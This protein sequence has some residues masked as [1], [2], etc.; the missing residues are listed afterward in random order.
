[1]H[2]TSEDCYVQIKIDKKLLKC[3]K[4]GDDLEIKKPKEEGLTTCKSSQ[5]DYKEVAGS[6]WFTTYA[7]QLLQSH[8][9]KNHHITKATL[10]GDKV[11]NIYLFSPRG[12]LH[13][14]LA[15]AKEVMDEELMGTPLQNMRFDFVPDK[16]AAFK[17][18][19][20]VC[21]DNATASYAEIAEGLTHNV[22]VLNNVIDETLKNTAKL[23]KTHARTLV[24]EH[25]PDWNSRIHEL[26]P[27]KEINPSTSKSLGM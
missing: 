21:L 7:G 23:T 15:K 4:C 26:F 6:P 11:P 8:L 3:P 24:V 20:V 16:E 2:V 1:M 9:E 14:F 22:L 25:I 19:V 17:Y 10:V 13:I 12:L 5:C 27:Q 18:R